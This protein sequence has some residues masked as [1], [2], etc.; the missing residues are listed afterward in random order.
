MGGKGR[1]GNQN[2]MQ[3]RGGRGGGQ[4]MGRGGNQ[5]AR[6]QGMGGDPA[7]R[8]AKAA[9]FDDVDDKGYLDHFF[10]DD[11]S[12]GPRKPFKVDGGADEVQVIRCVTKN[13]MMYI[14]NNIDKRAIF[15]N[16]AN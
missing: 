7:T 16:Q 8:A 3:G 6:A 12:F 1:G 2:Q 10:K 11:A 14:H 13:G 9:E 4:G 5:G 15:R